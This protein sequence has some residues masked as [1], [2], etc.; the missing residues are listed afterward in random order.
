MEMGLALMAFG[1]VY[2]LPLTPVVRTKMLH[3]LDFVSY[4]LVALSFG[5]L[6]LVLVM[7]RT[8]WWFEAPWIG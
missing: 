6:A 8:F 1:V 5:L 2:L 7:G 3:K 4:P